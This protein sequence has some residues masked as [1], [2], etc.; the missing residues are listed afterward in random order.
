[1]STD[2]NEQ[3]QGTVPAIPPAP[4]EFAADVARLAASIRLGIA[5]EDGW[6]GPSIKPGQLS[7]D[8][9]DWLASWLAGDGAVPRGSMLL[10]D[11]EPHMLRTHT[12]ARGG[13]LLNTLVSGFTELLRRLGYAGTVVAEES[14]FGG[15]NLMM[16][17]RRMTPAELSDRAGTVRG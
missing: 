3:P 13:D 7:D 10:A 5:A 2:P 9:I 17:A 1:M 14:P 15:W 4:N 12:S 16:A 6:D 8:E 11:T